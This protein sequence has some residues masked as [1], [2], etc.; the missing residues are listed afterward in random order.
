MPESGGLRRLRR[1]WSLVRL[2]GLGALP[3]TTPIG[4]NKSVRAKLSCS[5]PFRNAVTR[6]APE[7][8]LLL[9]AT[10]ELG[11]IRDTA[12]R[13]PRSALLRKFPHSARS[14]VQRG[15]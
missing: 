12:V 8:E 4:Y 9:N 10:G 11:Q 5:S 13:Q 3:E 2:L 14:P 1:R 6:S 7:R 15:N